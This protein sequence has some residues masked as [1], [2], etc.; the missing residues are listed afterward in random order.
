MTAEET[1]LLELEAELADD[2][3]LPDYAD[4]AAADAA[5][6][7]AEKP[8]ARKAKPKPKPKAE[9]NGVATAKTMAYSFAEIA[10]KL[11]AVKKYTVS[12]LDLDEESLVVA[13]PTDRFQVATNFD[14]HVH[15][16]KFSLTILSITKPIPADTR[17]MT[18]GTT[19][20]SLFRRVRRY[21]RTNDTPITKD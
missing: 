2:L 15:P 13:T 6:T 20:D 8:K 14:K 12:D 4:E 16:Q 1:A 11:D 7:A 19:S 3:D 5:A 9:S 10:A 17:K 18:E 21:I